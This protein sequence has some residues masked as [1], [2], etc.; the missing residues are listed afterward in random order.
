MTEKKPEGVPLDSKLGY[1]Y[2]AICWRWERGNDKYLCVFL[3][4]EKANSEYH[5]YSFYK[6]NE[7]HREDGPAIIAG[8][9]KTYYLNG[10]LYNA[11]EYQKVL[12]L[13]AFW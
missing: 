4:A 3:S 12:A 7:Y 9:T 8:P 13:K 2:P 1:M 10:K 6:N 11:I 5:R